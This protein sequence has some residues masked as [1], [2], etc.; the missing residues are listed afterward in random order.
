MIS[1]TGF[2][3]RLRQLI[4]QKEP[5]IA[6]WHAH[7]CCVLRTGR[8]TLWVPDGRGGRKAVVSQ[9][10]ATSVK[11]LRRRIERM[12]R[13]WATRGSLLAVEYDGASLA[14]EGDPQLLEALE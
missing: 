2:I 12:R 6:Y 14:A 1:A 5:F 4:E 7:G 8:V 11:K 10:S 3:E 9:A 13:G